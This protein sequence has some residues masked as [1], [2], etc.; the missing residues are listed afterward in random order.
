L[1][2][3][4]SSP[5]GFSAR[6]RNTAAVTGP[7]ILIALLQVLTI[8]PSRGNFYVLAALYAFGASGVFLQRSGG[9]DLA[10]N[11]RSSGEWK[12]PGNLKIAGMKYRSAWP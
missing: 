7:S 12:V 3:T 11:T 10:H 8:I 6:T 1:R 5:P 9:P 4:A 2:N